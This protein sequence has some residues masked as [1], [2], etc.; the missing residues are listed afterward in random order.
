MRFTDHRNGHITLE[1]TLDYQDL[2]QVG[3]ALRSAGLSLK[4]VIRDKGFYDDGT[5]MLEAA[6][7]AQ[8][9]EKEGQWPSTRSI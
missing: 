3:Y 6:W 4:G 1:W 2:E 9:R 7:E 5:A 8:E